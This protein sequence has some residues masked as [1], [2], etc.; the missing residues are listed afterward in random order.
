MQNCFSKNKRYFK[1]LYTDIH[2]FTE[3]VAIT[4]I[5]YVPITATQYVQITATQYLQIT[6][7]QYVPITETQYSALCI[8]SSF[9]HFMLEH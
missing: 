5:Q 3:Y 9:N 4:A 2:T 7:T 6:A 8:A 1:H